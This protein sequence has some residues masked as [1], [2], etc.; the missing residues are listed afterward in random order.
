MNDNT[1]YFL[2]YLKGIWVTPFR[3]MHRL[4]ISAAVFGS[5]GKRFEFFRSFIWRKVRNDRNE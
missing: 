2:H 5:N 3:R 1:N 4:S